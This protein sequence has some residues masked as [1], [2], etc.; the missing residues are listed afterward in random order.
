MTKFIVFEGIDG[1]GTT[2]QSELLKDY[3]LLQGEKAIVSPEPSDGIIG[4]FI[5][6]ILQ[7]KNLISHQ[8]QNFDEQMAYL[9]AADRYD[10]LYNE[11][12]GVFTLIKNN[13]YVISTRYYF[14]SLA[15]NGN[16]PEE[17]QLI[18]TLN[19]KFPQ[20]D[21]VIYLD[22]PVELSLERIKQRSL[23]EVYENKK[24]LTQVK[25]NYFKIF[26]DYQGF[27]LKIDGTQTT[28]IISLFIQDSVN[29]LLYY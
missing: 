17:W 1:S 4:K 13:Y 27:L 20:P 2:T 10:H 29:K 12:N 16:T 6:N 19:Q 21:L 8:N 15:Y 9:F 22:I 7:D 26:T 24:K 5:R 18:Q 3:L 11:K 25:E 14:S 28:D 23:H